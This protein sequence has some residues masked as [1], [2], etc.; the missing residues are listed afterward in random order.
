MFANRGSAFLDSALDQ[1]TA[2]T[3][4]RFFCQRIRH[5]AGAT[6]RSSECLSVHNT[7][8]ARICEKKVQIIV[9]RRQLRQ[10]KSTET[11]YYIALATS[12]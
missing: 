6:I 1:N 9:I 2:A 5:F 12:L 7:A 10:R 4:E 3:D 8:I 11:G